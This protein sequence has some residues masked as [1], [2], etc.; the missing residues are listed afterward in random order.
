MWLA[1][2]KKDILMEKYIRKVSPTFKTN[3][4]DAKPTHTLT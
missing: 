4:L 3:I 2:H 1:I